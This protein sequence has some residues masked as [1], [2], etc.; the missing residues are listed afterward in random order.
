MLPCWR[1]NVVV[2]V[3]VIAILVI[4][5]VVVVCIGGGRNRTVLIIVDWNSSI[6]AVGRTARGLWPLI[7]RR[8]QR[9]W[10]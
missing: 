6:G 1:E 9:R 7:Q 8:E 4:V 5:A 3:I 10:R 2:V